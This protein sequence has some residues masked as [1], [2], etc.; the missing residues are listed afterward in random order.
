MPEMEWDFPFFGWLR[1]HWCPTEEKTIPAE[2]RQ[3]RGGGSPNIA[4]EPLIN[5][6]GK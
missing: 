2:C 6:G 3:L 4:E 5:R 1:S